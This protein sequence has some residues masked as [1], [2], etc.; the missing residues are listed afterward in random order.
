M[1]RE[2][3]FRLRNLQKPQWFI[4]FSANGL[5]V[6]ENVLNELRRL[7]SHIVV[8][9]VTGSL[10]T[11]K[12]WILNQLAECGVENGF[13]VA[14]GQ[15]AVTSGI[16]ILCREHPILNCVVVFL[17]TEGLHD[18]FKT[19]TEQ[20]D[21]R[22]ST[23]SFLLSDK[24]IFNAKDKFD[25]NDLGKIGFIAMISKKLQQ[26]EAQESF[27]E[28][29][30][31]LRDVSRVKVKGKVVEPKEYLENILESAG[32]DDCR[33]SPKWCVREY[34]KK[35]A[36]FTLTQPT[37]FE[38]LSELGETDHP[39][40]KARFLEDKEKFKNYLFR[41]SDIKRLNNG[42]PYT[43]SAFCEYTRALVA[44]VE[45]GAIPNV[46]SLQQRIAEEENQR[47]WKETTELFRNSI[48][49][50]EKTNLYGSPTERFKVL[51][52][53][54]IERIQ[55]QMIPQSQQHMSEIVE[56]FKVFS[57]EEYKKLST[58]K[59]REFL[60]CH[61]ET[62]FNMIEDNCYMAPN[63]KEKFERDVRKVKEKYDKKE[64]LGPE[65]VNVWNEKE[66]EIRKKMK[67]L[68]LVDLRYELHSAETANKEEKDHL[69]QRIKRMEAEVNEQKLEMAR[70]AQELEQKRNNEK[71]ELEQERRRNEFEFE[72]KT[73]ELQKQLRQQEDKMHDR[74]VRIN[75]KEAAL[76]KA[77]EEIKESQTMQMQRESDA[78]VVSSLVDGISLIGAAAITALGNLGDDS[79]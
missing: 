12:S 64:N 67:E 22:L 3:K 76:T 1:S 58:E 28:F 46:S 13:G 79:E 19:N 31:L 34:C 56:E 11:G 20:E 55:N 60:T 38:D 66:R 45:D 21:N 78:K 35:R 36:C 65:K 53:E 49:D 26:R 63:A 48:R 77:V 10:R 14:D 39:E 41:N 51:Q 33:F 32:P 7:E 4:R 71:L 29:I 15:T 23:L 70:K 40:L 37:E 17:D 47:V 54:G 44:T 25:N 43:T 68:E 27:P 61:L 69:D 74:E 8:F 24:F 75:E 16:W 30:L 9:T 59:C 52:K 2:L 57:E 42:S 18:P 73:I 72:M 6:N 5:D 62:C 50:D